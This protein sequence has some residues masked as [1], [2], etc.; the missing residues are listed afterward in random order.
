[1]PTCVRL[2]F[3]RVAGTVCTGLSAC[4]S[5]SLEIA[6]LS[7]GS[8]IA[9]ASPQGLCDRGALHASGLIDLGFPAAADVP[10]GNTIAVADTGGD[11][12]LASNH[13]L[14]RRPSNGSGTWS[15]SGLDDRLVRYILS[16]PERSMVFAGSGRASGAHDLGSFHRSADG[17]R[18][19]STGGY[20]AQTDNGTPVPIVYLARAPGTE[21]SGMG[22]V[23][24]LVRLA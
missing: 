5:P 10:D 11:V 15:R 4:A 20:F 9:E 18:T 8:P 24:K 7:P 22:A 2:T 12:L 6:P 19:W 14:W 13:G 1:M 17:G 23:V 21:A 3:L 16:V